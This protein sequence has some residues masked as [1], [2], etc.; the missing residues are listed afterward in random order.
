[1]NHPGQSSLARAEVAEPIEALRLIFAHP[2]VSPAECE[3]QAQAFCRLARR[4]HWH[5]GQAWL[6]QRDGAVRAACLLVVS[7]GRCGT[8]L[9]SV[10]GQREDRAALV[11]GLVQLVTEA[12]RADLRM[13]QALLE[14]GS[15]AADLLSQAGFGL[16]STLLYM[17]R[18]ADR[19]FQQPPQEG[20]R[21]ASYDAD[22]HATFAEVIQRS[23]ETTLDCPGLDGVR[24][25]DE[26]IEAHKASGIFEPKAWRLLLRTGQAVGVLLLNRVVYSSA[27][28]I[29]Y[30][31]LTPAARGRGLSRVLVAQALRE[32]RQRHLQAVSLAV[33]S[34]NLPARRVYESF[35][36]A[37]RMAREAWVKILRRAD[38]QPA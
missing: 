25:I 23:Y 22:T 18:Q 13:V 15:G 1:V 34:A 26:V 35:D 29:V 9:L 10:P 27:L 24:S 36:F 8:A 37:T 14:P 2:G 31:G 12:R 17:E 38:G 6:V 28:E 4:Q 5:A 11:Q 33:D 20:L 3:R 30:M 19:P 21:W 16:L 7:P 32:A